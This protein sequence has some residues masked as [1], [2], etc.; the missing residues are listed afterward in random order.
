VG[1]IRTLRS[2]FRLYPDLVRGGDEIRTVA[3][4]L[5]GIEWPAST[6]AEAIEGAYVAVYGEPVREALA[7]L[8]AEERAR[9]AQ[10][11]IQGSGNQSPVPDDSP[12]P[13]E[14]GTGSDS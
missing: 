13:P 12:A 7:N 11:A 2:A 6:T 1:A 8:V 10:A 4:L 14:D 5:D 3:T 9:Q